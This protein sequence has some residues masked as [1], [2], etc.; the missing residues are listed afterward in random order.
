MNINI[1]QH[2]NNAIRD[3][4][5]ATRNK[6]KSQVCKTF[7]FKIDYNHLNLLQKVHL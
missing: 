6:R 5:I 3:A 7:K 1:L 2:R 4:I